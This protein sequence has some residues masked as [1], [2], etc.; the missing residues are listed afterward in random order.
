MILLAIKRFQ[1]LEEMYFFFR[2]GKRVGDNKGFEFAQYLL[3]VV[4]AQ[5]AQCQRVHCGVLVFLYLPFYFF[6]AVRQSMFPVL[7]SITL[8]LFL[9]HK[10]MV[11]KNLF[12]S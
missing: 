1:F 11:I 8:C 6:A 10:V 5:A 3:Q 7:C 2:A 9:K 4:H 12:Y